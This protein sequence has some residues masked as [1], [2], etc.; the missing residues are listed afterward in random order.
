MK[1]TNSAK[2]TVPLPSESSRLKRSCKMAAHHPG[3]KKKKLRQR[4]NDS[5]VQRKIR[6]E[7]TEEERENRN[8][9]QAVVELV[10]C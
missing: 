9:E 6:D 10:Y 7:R 8:A 2:E 1:A 3:V 4:R 5:R